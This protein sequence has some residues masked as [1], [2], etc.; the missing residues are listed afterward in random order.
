MSAHGTNDRDIQALTYLVR[1]LREETYGAGQ[2][3]EAGIVVKLTELRGQ[4]L[5]SVVE[6]ALCHATDPEAKTPGALLRPFLPPKPSERPKGH[7]HPPTKAEAC[8]RCGQAQPCHCTREDRA[9]TYDDEP[10][11][12]RMTKATALAQMRADVAASRQQEEV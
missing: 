1:R 7:P 11:E 12:G 4:N 2:W 10:T 3:D 5:A 8:R 6:R 9:A